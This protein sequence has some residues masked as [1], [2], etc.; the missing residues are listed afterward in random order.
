MGETGGGAKT[1]LAPEVWKSFRCC[2]LVLHATTVRPETLALAGMLFLSLVIRVRIV[3]KNV[4]P[5]PKAQGIITL[6][7]VYTHSSVDTDVLVARHTSI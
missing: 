2:L 5:G 1:I 7:V 6:D 4:W 3:S